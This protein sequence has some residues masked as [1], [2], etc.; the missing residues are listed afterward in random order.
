MAGNKILE[1]F[2]KMLNWKLLC[3]NQKGNLKVMQDKKDVMLKAEPKDK[4]VFVQTGG[5]KPIVHE[6]IKEYFIDIK[7]E[8]MLYPYLYVELKLG[9]F[10]TI[11]Q[12][13]KYTQKSNRY[14]AKNFEL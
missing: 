14:N 8:S 11:C 3:V 7:Q 2:A 6:N 13:C 5:T 9:F 1:E 12:K 4:E 10:D